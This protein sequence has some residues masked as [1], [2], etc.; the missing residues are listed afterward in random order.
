MP[1]GPVRCFP[2]AAALA[3]GFSASS[4]RGGILPTGR[5]LGSR[6]VGGATVGVEGVSDTPAHG[7]D[8]ILRGKSGVAFASLWL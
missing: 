6:G 4:S 2:Q 1:A 7:V 5:T 3:P 8:R